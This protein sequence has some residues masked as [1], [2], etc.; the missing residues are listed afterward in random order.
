MSQ[1]KALTEMG[2]K[3]LTKSVLLAI[4]NAVAETAKP[5]KC[6]MFSPV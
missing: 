6:P 4:V 1:L 5:R 3:N 2:V